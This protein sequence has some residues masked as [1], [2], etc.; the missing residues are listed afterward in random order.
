MALTRRDL[1]MNFGHAAITGIGNLLRDRETRKPVR[2][3]S[4]DRISRQCQSNAVFVAA[5][6][7][8]H[9]DPHL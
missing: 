7:Y 8:L 6:F 4:K 1:M 5:D 3:N 2:F 9:G